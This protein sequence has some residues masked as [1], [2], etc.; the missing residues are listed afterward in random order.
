[1][2]WPVWLPLS[3]LHKIVLRQDALSL[4]TFET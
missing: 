3:F 1:M 4:E 2:E